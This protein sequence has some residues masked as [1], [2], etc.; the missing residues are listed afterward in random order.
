M[1]YLLCSYLSLCDIINIHILPLNSPQRLVLTE[2]F[3]RYFF[4]ATACGL[5]TMETKLSEVRRNT[6]PRWYLC[7]LPRVAGYVTEKFGECC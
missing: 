3:T 2:K 4:T 5:V 7:L 1:S 6:L